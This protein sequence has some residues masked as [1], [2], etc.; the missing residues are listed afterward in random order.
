MPL[1]AVCGPY[2]SREIHRFLNLE[3]KED[4]VTNRLS[5]LVLDLELGILALVLEQVDIADHGECTD[6]D[7]GEL[8]ASEWGLQWTCEDSRCARKVDVRRQ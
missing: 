6:I 7:I 5:S 2:R 3:D 1:T 4:I 8:K